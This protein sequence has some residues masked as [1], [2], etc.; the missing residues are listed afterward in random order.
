MKDKNRELLIEIKGKL[1][2]IIYCTD[3]GVA[4]A[5]CDVVETLEGILDDEKKDK[6]DDERRT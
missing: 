2:G 6:K 3:G 5:L 1:D 4:D